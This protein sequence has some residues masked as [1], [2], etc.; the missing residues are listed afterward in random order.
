M[1]HGIIP[2]RFIEMQTLF[3]VAG[4]FVAKSGLERVEK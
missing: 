2:A 1:A 3:S 4:L